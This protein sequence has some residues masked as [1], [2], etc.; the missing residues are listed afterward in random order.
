MEKL[1]NELISDLLLT[2]AM[3]DYAKQ[4]EDEEINTLNDVID[5]VFADGALDREKYLHSIM[6]LT[7][8]GLVASDIEN[9]E[10]IEMSEAVG[11]DIAGLTSKGLEYID[12]LQNEPTMGEKIRNF[13]RAFNDACG[14]VAD[15]GVVKL[16]GTVVL[17][18]L[19]LLV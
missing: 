3:S 9:E 2:K 8:S 17:P 10:D 1:N 11:Y 6:E 18:I 7:T 15:N 19:G 14:E 16:A 5:L 12:S 4:S 13:F